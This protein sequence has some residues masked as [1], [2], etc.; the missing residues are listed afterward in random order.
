MTAQILAST[1]VF[2]VSLWDKFDKPKYRVLRGILF[3]ILG[4]LAAVPFT[5]Q[6][7]FVEDRYLPNLDLQYWILGGAMYII[8]ATIYM[9]RIPEKFFP[10]KFDIFVS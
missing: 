6:G 1:S 3:V 10:S 7:I 4:L 2:I 9:L 8:G 5:H